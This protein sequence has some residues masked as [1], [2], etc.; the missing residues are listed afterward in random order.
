[1]CK[2][3]RIVGYVRVSTEGQADDGVSLDA[4]RAKLAAYAVALDLNLVAVVEDA[5]ASAK[6]LARPGL[7]EAL[8]ML[9]GGSETGA[10]FAPSPRRSRSRGTPRSAVGLGRPRPFAKFSPVRGSPIP[11][12]KPRRAR[13]EREL[14]WVTL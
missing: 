5:G 7:Q 3:T 2:R 13:Y 4:Q 10:R 11:T 1:M 8:A 6:T 12:G 14:Q 9:T